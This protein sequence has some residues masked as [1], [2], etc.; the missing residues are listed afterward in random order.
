MSFD[1]VLGTPPR[2]RQNRRKTFKAATIEKFNKEMVFRVSTKMGIEA[3]SSY[4]SS[5]E[6]CDTYS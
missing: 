1:N 4:S 6:E 2:P 3:D 5:A